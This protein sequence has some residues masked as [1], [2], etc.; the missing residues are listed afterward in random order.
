MQKVQDLKL[1]I[2]ADAERS[3]IEIRCAE[4]GVNLETL[5]RELEESTDSDAIGLRVLK[6]MTDE[7]NHQQ[8]RHSEFL[9]LGLKRRATPSA[10]LN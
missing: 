10:R 8:F 6:H 5:T 3:D 4:S 1:R 7:L 2:R 9:V